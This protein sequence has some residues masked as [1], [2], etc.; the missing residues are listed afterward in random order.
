MSNMERPFR[1]LGWQLKLLREQLSQ[2][3]A[4][5]S[6]AVE[7]DTEILELIEQGLQRPNED[8]LFLLISHFDV[9]DAEASSLWELAGY[10]DSIGLSKEDLPL[11]GGNN[12]RPLTV[13]F[14]FD[15]RVVYTD[16]LHVSVND[17]G[18]VMNFMQGA[19][20]SNQSIPVAR[21]GM[22]KKHARKVL[23]VLKQSLEQAD[24][25]KQPKLLLPRVK[26][27]SKTKHRDT[28]DT[29]SDVY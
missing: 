3:L 22:S 24:K 5:V 1:A 19:G 18:V 11:L 25:P 13:A 4:E 6:G 14:P 15:P 2:T 8:V 20:Q 9:K 27:P 10:T 21:I 12:E 28:T 7:I 26:K 16:H 17:Y 23:E 29:N